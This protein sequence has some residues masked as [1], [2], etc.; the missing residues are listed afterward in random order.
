MQRLTLLTVGKVK[1]SWI[2][3]GCAE[4]FSRMRGGAK[5]EV[6]EVSAGK[7]KDPA[8]QREEEGAKLIAAIRKI[9]GDAW[10]LDEKGERMTSHEFAFFLSQAK[11]VG[12]HVVF[13]LGGAY[14]LS[15]E[16]RKTAKGS[17]RLSDMTFPHELCRLVFAEQLYR[18]LEI[19][20]GSGY[21]H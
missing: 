20:K 13:V 1:T 21:H 8:K 4:Y 9:D 2:N 6:L 14:G 3:E 7:E 15:T 5:L 11:D 10:V 17:L 12:R 16:V 18:A 19:S